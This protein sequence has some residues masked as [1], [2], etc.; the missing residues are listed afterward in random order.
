M[1][2]CR[3][4]EESQWLEQAERQWTATQTAEPAPA[5]IPQ[6]VEDPMINPFCDGRNIIVDFWKGEK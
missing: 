2:N 4:A 1:Q 3:I 6:I 5:L